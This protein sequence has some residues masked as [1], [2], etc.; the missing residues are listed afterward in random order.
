MPGGKN[1]DGSFHIRALVSPEFG[2]D[3]YQDLARADNQSRRIMVLAAKGKAYENH[4]HQADALARLALLERTVASIARTLERSGAEN[5][6]LAQEEDAG[7]AES[8]RDDLPSVVMD[9]GEGG[10]D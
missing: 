5:V 9:E 7:S 8:E 10:F 2:D 6:V 4:G 1:R 3:V